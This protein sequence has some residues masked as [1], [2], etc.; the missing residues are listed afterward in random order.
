[1][2]NK[3]YLGWDLCIG[4]ALALLLFPLKWV[5]AWM[6]A[7]AVHELGHIGAVYL[8][9]GKIH[10]IT[11]RLGGAKLETDYLSPRQELFC[12]LAGPAA[13]LSLL[14]VGRW[15][16]RTALLALAQSAYNLLPLFPLDGGR[17]LRALAKKYPPKLGLWMERGAVAAMAVLGLWISFSLGPVPLMVLAVLLLK[18]NSPCK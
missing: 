13:G 6:L 10:G 12:A 1:M 15:L 14:L 18:R 3:L 5:L 16:P 9:H 7:A 4:T 2:R 11:L 8:C 17:A